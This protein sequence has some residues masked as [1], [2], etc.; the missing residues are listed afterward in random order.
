MEMCYGNRSLQ[1]HLDILRVSGAYNV[2]NI[3]AVRSVERNSE[4]LAR[5]A[6][7]CQNAACQV[8]NKNTFG[9]SLSSGA[10]YGTASFFPFTRMDGA[11]LPV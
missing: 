5:S 4:T 3:Y 9:L 6:G 2:D 8:G 7:R 10:G 11:V 1:F